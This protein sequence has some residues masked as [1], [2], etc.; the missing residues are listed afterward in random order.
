MNLRGKYRNA[1]GTMTAAAIR[2]RRPFL[3]RNLMLGAGLAS[4]AGFCYWW[5]YR[6]LTPDDFGDVPV[7]E[8]SEGELEELRRKHNARL[9]QR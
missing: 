6:A 4:F 8:L 3:A 1:D 9:D 7:P 2:A 5:T